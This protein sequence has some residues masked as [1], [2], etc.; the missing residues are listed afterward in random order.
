MSSCKP[1]DTP[2]SKCE[3][4]SLKMCH[5]NRKEQREMASLPYYIT[6]GSLMYAILCTLPDIYF[7]VGLV[8]RYKL[9]H[10]R[11]NWKAVKR[12]LRYLKGTMDYC[13]CY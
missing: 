4:L 5:N 2:M 9:I 10:G 1:M 7:T 3:A 11:E 6:M 8:S 13:L 12:I